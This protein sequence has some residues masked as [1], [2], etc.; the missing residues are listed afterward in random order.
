VR[1]ETE[2]QIVL[3]DALNKR[4]E[5]RRDFFDD[6]DDKIREAQNSLNELDLSPFELQLEKIR[7]N[8]DDDLVGSIQEIKRQ[9]EDGL[10]TTD[11]YLSEIKTLEDAANTTF[12]KLTELAK[13]QRDA[14]RS[15]EF[16]WRKAFES[17]QDNATNAAKKAGE[18]F[19]KVTKGMED[20]IVNFVK[21][22]K[23]EFKDLIN[24]ILEQLLRSQIQQVIAQTFGSIGGG[25]AGGSS[26]LSNLFSGFFANGG[27]IPA[28]TFGV[29]G[30][31]GPELVTGPGTVT[32]LGTG[33]NVTYNINAVDARS[34][35]QLVASD[36]GFIHAVASQGANKVPMGR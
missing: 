2:R 16:G 28:G 12:T 27:T 5:I 36:P 34:F 29:V 17:Y 4:I 13:Q 21:T 22:G 33:G 31:N 18:V 24:D 25:G 30:E 6:M 14:Q 10:I 7:Q 1:E 9:W 8:I 26:L 23:F 35:K 20:T 32:P 19:N 3:E 15:F 11:Q